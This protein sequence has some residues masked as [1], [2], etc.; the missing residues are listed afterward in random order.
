[1][2][3]NTGIGI[4][5]NKPMGQGKVLPHTPYYG[6]KYVDKYNYSLNEGNCMKEAVKNLFGAWSVAGI[7]FFVISAVIVS[8]DNNNIAEAELYKLLIVIGLSGPV[9]WMCVVIASLLRLYRV[10]LMA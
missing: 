9:V 1:M 10:W 5:V 4:V 7:V 8:N 6:V 2:E 3:H